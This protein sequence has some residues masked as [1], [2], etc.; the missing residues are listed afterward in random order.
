M[1]SLAESIEGRRVE[2]HRPWPRLVV[3]PDAWR[4]TASDLAAG[5]ATL[6]G[7]W[8]DADPAPLVHMALADAAAG[9][10]L[11]VSLA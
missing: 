1:P 6:L 9:E 4:R 11:V 5:R 3:T 8:G 7:L 2:S 10:I